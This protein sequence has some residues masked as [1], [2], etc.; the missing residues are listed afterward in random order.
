MRIALD[1]GHGYKQRF[2]TGAQGCGIVEDD[3][4]LM[5]C[6]RLGHYL[7]AKGADVIFTREKPAIVNL[8]DRGKIAK[9]AKCDLFVSIHLNAAAN[10][11]AHGCEAF[12]AGVTVKPNTPE[13]GLYRR[14]KALGIAVL[15]VIQLAGIS[16]RG[17]KPDSSSQH[18]S[19]RVL[20][21]TWGR[22]P[23]VLVE[24]GFLSNPGDA[25]KL[26]DKRWVED[27]AAKLAEVLV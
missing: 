5:F 16:S 8:G 10:A 15:N 3:W 27:L 6:Q 24:V 14:S 22:M 19:L 26:K 12:Y 13:A 9:K 20:R 7:R 4:A 1:A 17:L 23:A 21:D 18:T 2:P 11:Q 25:S